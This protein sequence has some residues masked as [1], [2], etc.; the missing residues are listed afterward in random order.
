MQST[1]LQETTVSATRTFS[2]LLGQGA[3]S[4]RQ[5]LNELCSNA[6]QKWRLS[7]EM[8]REAWSQSISH[9]TVNQDLPLS[10]DSVSQEANC[11]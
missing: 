6:L 9:E 11:R 10:C 7:E 8:L 4:C 2:V 5:Q 3:V 1:L